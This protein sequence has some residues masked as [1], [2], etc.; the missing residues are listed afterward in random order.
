MHSKN[1]RFHLQALI[2]SSLQLT[3]Q[4]HNTTTM[5]H[6]EHCSETSAQNLQQKKEVLLHNEITLELE[7]ASEHNSTK[8]YH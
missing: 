3:L 4:S 6:I 8:F 2:L 7:N 5:I 1:Y